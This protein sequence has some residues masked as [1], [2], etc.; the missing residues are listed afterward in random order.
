MLRLLTR[1]KIIPET[2]EIESS[3]KAV[4]IAP[5]RASPMRRLLAGTKR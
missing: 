5:A 4:T 1:S 3:S 2:S